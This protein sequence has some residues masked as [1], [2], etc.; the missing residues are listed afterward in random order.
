MSD[1]FLTILNQVLFVSS[2]NVASSIFLIVFI[3]SA[4]ESNENFSSAFICCRPFL[5]TCWSSW[6]K[7]FFAT[8]SRKK[9]TFASSAPGVDVA[10]NKALVIPSIK[11]NSSSVKNP[12]LNSLSFVLQEDRNSL[13]MVGKL[14]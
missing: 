1:N 3:F 2:L 12:A 13:R 14:L 4:E 11:W 10:G 7:Q 6:V 5:I 9:G 8:R